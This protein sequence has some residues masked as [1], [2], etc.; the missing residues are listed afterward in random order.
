MLTLRSTDSASLVLSFASNSASGV[1]SVFSPSDC[2]LSA[3]A[4]DFPSAAGGV[5]SSEYC[6][7]PSATRR[8]GNAS[9]SREERPIVLDDSEA[10]QE[11]KAWRTCV[12]FIVRRGE[13]GNW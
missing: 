1:I 4:S 2:F 9:A 6:R 10:V 11:R 3:S 8:E 7:A 12:G 13:R 5:L